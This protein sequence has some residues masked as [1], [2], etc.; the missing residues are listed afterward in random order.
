MNLTS[1]TNLSINISDF[2]A[3]IDD[4]ES[5][6]EKSINARTLYKTIGIEITLKAFPGSIRIIF[7][8]QNT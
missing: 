4:F 1:H 7:F 5:E 6:K 3:A 8:K 2:M